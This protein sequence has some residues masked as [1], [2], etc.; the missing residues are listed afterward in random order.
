MP[1]SKIRWLK[2]GVAIIDGTFIAREEDLKYQVTQDGADLKL[3][4]NDV[5]D[6]DAGKY[7]VK[8]E[9]AVSEIDVAVRGKEF[10]I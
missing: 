7:A 2:D 5:V 10:T 6:E 9:E 4:V 8:V 1:V 3:V